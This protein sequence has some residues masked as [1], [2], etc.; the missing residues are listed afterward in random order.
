M[1]KVICFG[2]F[3][4]LHEGHRSLFTQARALGDH[5]TVIIAKDSTIRHVKKRE[6]YQYEQTRLLA[7]CASG[8]VDY[9]RLGR[10]DDVYAVLSEERPDVICLGYDQTHFVDRLESELAKQGIIARIVRA[11]AHEPQTQK[12][13]LLRKK[14]HFF[15]K[16]TNRRE[17]ITT[18]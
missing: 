17:C 4:P 14:S 16:H 18:Q 3:D 8:L 13:T 15:P 2:T 12:S 7:V 10:E 11:E 5:V 9:A 6:P 1:I